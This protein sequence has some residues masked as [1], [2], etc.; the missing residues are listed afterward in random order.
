MIK[1][2]KLVKV[3][4]NATCW[5]LA[6]RYQSFCQRIKIN[7]PNAIPKAEA[8]MGDNTI[9]SDKP[10]VLGKRGD[11][12]TVGI[13]IKENWLRSMSLLPTVRAVLFEK[14]CANAKRRGCHLRK[15]QMFIRPVPYYLFKR[16]W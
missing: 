7:L 5:I 11:D 9:A 16:E 4:N 14:A 2:A 1:K 3:S 8:V 10:R 6:L 13:L 12:T 15:P